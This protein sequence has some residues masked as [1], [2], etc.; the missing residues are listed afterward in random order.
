LHGSGIFSEKNITRI[1]LESS[2]SDIS[3]E[4]SKATNETTIGGNPIFFFGQ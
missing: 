4:E 1:I 3:D 2:K